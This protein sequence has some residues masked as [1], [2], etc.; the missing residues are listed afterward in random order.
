MN[1]CDV[2]I[3]TTSTKESTLYYM[4]EFVEYIVL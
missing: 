3:Y 2:L 4:I 1:A